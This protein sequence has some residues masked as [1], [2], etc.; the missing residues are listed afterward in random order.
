MTDQPSGQTAAPARTDQIASALYAIR[1]VTLS[2]APYGLVVYTIGE[3]VQL[4][5]ASFTKGLV[6]GLFAAALLAI[7]PKAPLSRGGA[8]G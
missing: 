3:A 2:L 8:N 5:D 7:N 1:D 4:N 6:Q